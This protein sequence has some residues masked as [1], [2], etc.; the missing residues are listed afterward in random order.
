MT[1]RHSPSLLPGR[2]SVVPPTAPRMEA[3]ERRGAWVVGA[4]DSEVPLKIPGHGIDGP[5]IDD[6]PS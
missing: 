1:P 3:V 5:C 6:F 4:L 2:D